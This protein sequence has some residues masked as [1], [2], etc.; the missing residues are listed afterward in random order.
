[1]NSPLETEVGTQVNPS[2]AEADVPDSSE[3][4]DVEWVI[5]A[6][7][8]SEAIEEAPSLE[9]VFGNAFAMEELQASAGS[10]IVPLTSSS[11]SLQKQH[12]DLVEST[13][14]PET[15]EVAVQSI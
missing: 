8:I 5:G 7:N 2:P 6:T 13:Q 4:I 10:S 3:I 15:L 1:M 14:T 12:S 9:E 11:N